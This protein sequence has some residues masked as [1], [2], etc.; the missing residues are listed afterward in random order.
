M[1]DAIELEHRLSQLEA[2]IERPTNHNH[3]E[4]DDLFN[5]FDQESQQES[6]GFGGTG[7]TSNSA[8]DDE[9]DTINVRD[10][11]NKLSLDTLDTFHQAV[12]NVTIHDDASMMQYD[13]KNFNNAEQA[14]AGA[15]INYVHNVSGDTNAIPAYYNQLPYQNDYLQ[16]VYQD[17]MYAQQMYQQPYQQQQQ[18]QYQQQYQQSPPQSYQQPAQQQSPLQP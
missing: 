11:R 13:G 5:E 7:S 15:I 4:D 12:D 1:D 3:A 18:H 17:Q 14:Q 16:R 8:T 2:A 9:E 10:G 6:S